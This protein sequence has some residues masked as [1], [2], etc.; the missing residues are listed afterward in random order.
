[1]ISPFR[2][3]LEAEAQ[4]RFRRELYHICNTLF[5]TG[6]FPDNIKVA[7]GVSLYKTG[8]NNLFTNDRNVSL[9]SKYLKNYFVTE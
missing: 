8:G 2:R 6:I 9:L 4:F 3:W 5:I 7:R 1:M